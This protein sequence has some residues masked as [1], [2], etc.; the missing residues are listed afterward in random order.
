MKWIAISLALVLAGCGAPLTVADLKTDGRKTETYK[1]DKTPKE[2]AACAAPIYDLFVPSYD[3]ARIEARQT[4]LEVFKTGSYGGTV[5]IM[6]MISVDAN[7]GGS[8]IT[9]YAAD[10]GINFDLRF[11]EIESV[12]RECI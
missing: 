5:A 7:G 8:S 12:I 1:S 6:G 3:R 9:G 2:F 4:G 11:K 10:S